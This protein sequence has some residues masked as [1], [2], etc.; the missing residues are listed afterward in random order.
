MIAGGK[1]RFKFTD[2][3]KI[4]F[5]HYLEWRMQH[6]DP[7]LTKTRLCG[8]VAKYVSPCCNQISSYHTC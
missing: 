1:R 4:F 5:I 6:A 2:A 8:E 7:L 3:D